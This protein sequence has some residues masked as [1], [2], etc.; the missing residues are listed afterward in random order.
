MKLTI[1]KPYWDKPITDEVEQVTVTKV[2]YHMRVEVKGGKELGDGRIQD[3]QL[4]VT[5]EL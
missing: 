4:I 1:N 2:G 3:D 5:V